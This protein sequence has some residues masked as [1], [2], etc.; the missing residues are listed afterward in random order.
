MQGHTWSFIQRTGSELILDGGPLFHFETCVVS[1]GS[2]EQ[3]EEAGVKGGG[4]GTKPRAVSGF[5]PKKLLFVFS[6]SL[7]LY[8]SV[9]YFV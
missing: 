3:S 2:R 1:T 6:L 4:A 8:Q 5:N 7:L 9:H